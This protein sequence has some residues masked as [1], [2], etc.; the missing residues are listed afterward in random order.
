M[1]AMMRRVCLVLPLFL[2]LA[3]PTLATD[4]RP[5]WGIS[6]TENPDVAAK[7]QSSHVVLTIAVLEE[8]TL[9]NIDLSGPGWSV[10]PGQGRTIKGHHPQTGS[11]KKILHNVRQPRQIC[12]TG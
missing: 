11:R 8:L 3:G 5:T 10:A 12:A 6:V 2:C 7:G 1:S 9:E 4:I